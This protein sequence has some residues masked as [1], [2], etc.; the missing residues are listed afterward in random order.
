MPKPNNTIESLMK[1]V[2]M[3]SNGC[4]EWTGRVNHKGYGK[5]SWQ[6]KDKRVHRVMFEHFHGPVPDGLQVCHHCDNPPCC[7]P[8]HLFAGTAMDNEWDKIEK[9]NYASKPPAVFGPKM[10]LITYS[11]RN[12]SRR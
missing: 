2:A 3:Q 11:I 10:D 1:R 4:W 6:G 5:V 7:N 8:D 9:R 12:H